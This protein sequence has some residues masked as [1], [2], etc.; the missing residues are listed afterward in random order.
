[1]AVS[2]SLKFYPDPTA[3][4]RSRPV[5]RRVNRPLLDQSARLGWNRFGG[6]VLSNRDAL[7]QLGVFDGFAGFNDFGDDPDSTLGNDLFGT[8]STLSA[9]STGAAV[10]DWQTIL[11][12]L[13]TGYNVSASGQF[14]A[15]TTA[16]TKAFQ[17]IVGITADG[18]VGGQTRRAVQAAAVQA[19]ASQGQQPYLGFGVQEMTNLFNALPTSGA[20]GPTG[21]DVATQAA[22]VLPKAVARQVTKAQEAVQTVSDSTGVPPFVIYGA[23]VAGALLVGFGVYGMLTRGKK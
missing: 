15:N 22:A 6:R 2:R 1:M 10:S 8:S 17:S 18:K 19:R 4:I 9:G 12:L 13:T 14:D 7:A 20:L 21:A 11:G 16:A 3:M 23:G 5:P